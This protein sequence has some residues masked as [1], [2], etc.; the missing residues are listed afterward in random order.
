MLRK[1]KMNRSEA[2]TTRLTAKRNSAAHVV[3]ADFSTLL[4]PEVLER[5]WIAAPQLGRRQSDITATALQAFAAPE[6]F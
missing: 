2:A 6:G 4:P 3:L 1:D 5:L